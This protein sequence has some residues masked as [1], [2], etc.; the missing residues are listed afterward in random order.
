M[1]GS[2]GWDMT[3][4]HSLEGGAEWFRKKADATCV[5]VVRG[6]DLAF[7]IAP[8]VKLEDAR[9][10]IEFALAGAAEELERRRVEAEEA[11][12]RKR[13]AKIAGLR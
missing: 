12:T 8:G 5:F 1:S 11:E 2:R 7:A 9:Q 6:G 3:S 4:T 13:A 10:A